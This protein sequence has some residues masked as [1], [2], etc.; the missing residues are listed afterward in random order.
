MGVGSL[1]LAD[2]VNLTNQE[3]ESD[4][5][6]RAT[7]TL[8][9]HHTAGTSDA[10]SR[11]LMDPGGRTVSANYLLLRDGTLMEVILLGRRAYTSASGFDHESI[12]VEVVNQTAGPEW[13]IS[14]TQRRRL[15]KLARDL[16]AL[17][18]IHRLDRGVG[19]I[20]GHFE[21]PG[22]Y[23]TACPGPSMQL[24]HIS[25]LAKSGSTVALEDEAPIDLGDIEMRYLNVT[26]GPA[27]NIGELSFEPISVEQH[28]D[29]WAPHFRVASAAI[30]NGIDVS[31]V[32][33]DIARQGVFN[34]QAAFFSALNAA[35]TGV[36][37]VALTAAVKAAVQEALD[38]ENVD[39]N[40]IDVAA[41]VKAQAD[42]LA[43]RLAS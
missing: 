25:A 15:A 9:I 21:V 29:E 28:G 5:R 20:I 34:R 24:D 2:V 6:N 41:L 43:A 38:D 36:D 42:E 17:S 7:T 26:N 12:T 39:S 4:P 27:A 13:G 16:H 23:A 35:A 22:T 14:E 19:G 11:A 1:G 10:G 40:T 31:Q 32:V 8:Q 37:P 18:L 3:T 33:F 30:F